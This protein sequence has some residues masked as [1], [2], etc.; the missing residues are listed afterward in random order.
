MTRN[1]L[2]RLF[3]AAGFSNSEQMT[4]ELFAKYHDLDGVISADAYALSSLIGERAAMLVKLSAALAS[5]RDTEK[6]SVG[7][8]C[9]PLAIR[10]FLIALFRGCSVEMVY[11]VC[12]DKNDRVLA[13][14][15]VGEGTVNSANITP[16]RLVDIAVK[17]RAASV[18]IAHNHPAGRVE[19]SRQDMS[20]TNSLGV[21]L[22]NVGIRLAAHYTVA[23]S[24]CKKI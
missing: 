22:D 14:E 4:E 12:L 20:F 7:D 11:T 6:L 10:E 16:R 13:V 21:M 18:I 19:P 3:D 1:T 24:N 5:R 23:G 9:D 17:N 15:P 8:K 2:K